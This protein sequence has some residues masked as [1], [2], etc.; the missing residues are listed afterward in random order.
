[1]SELKSLI[2]IVDDDAGIRSVLRLLMEREGYSV[3]EAATGV[4]AIA[5][6]EQHHPDVVLMDIRMPVMDGAAA[7]ARIQ[8]LPDG[9]R[10]P[11]LM[12][13]ALDDR[14]S[15]DRCFEAGATDYI[16]KPVNSAVMRQRVRRLLRTRQAEN[17]LRA[18]EARLASIIAI[19]ADAIVLTDAELNIRLFNP[20]AERIFG[21]RAA[22][23]M[24][25]P[26]DLLMPDWFVPV[27]ADRVMKMRLGE[28][29]G[30]QYGDYREGMGRH[31]DGHEFPIEISVGRIEE[32]P[33]AAYT[34][35][36]RDITRRKQAEA[37]IEQRVQ[38]LAALG[39]IGQVVTTQLELDG[40][41][42]A[43]IDQV[44]ARLQA[45]G[46]SVL[47]P[48]GDSEL[49]FAAVNGASADRLLGQRIPASAG[50]AGEVLHSG[51]AAR[52]Q[53]TNAHDRAYRD[54]EQISEYHARDIIAVPLKLGAEVIGVME[55]VH[56][57]PASFS[58]DDARLL[59]AAADWAAI[60]IG[61]ARQHQALQRRLQESE[62]MAA[63]GRALNQTLD[64]D[65][66]LKLIVNSAQRIIPSADRAA[67]I[68]VDD[69][70]NIASA[71]T[72]DGRIDQRL[73]DAAFSLNDEPY[74]TLMIDRQVVHLPDLAQQADVRPV[75]LPDQT[76]AMLAAPLQSGSA[77]FGVIS[78]YSLR[79]RAFAAEDERLL[80]MLGDEAAIA[81]HNARLYTSEHTQR[82]LAE[83]LRD[84][85]ATLTGTLDL[86]EVLDR[87]LDNAGRV[88][89]HDSA[90]ILLAEAGVARAARSRGYTD[91]S[92]NE[93][94]LARRYSIP[95]TPH[96][97]QMAEELHPLLIGNTARFEGWGELPQAAEVK[98]FVGAQIRFKRKLLGFL[99]LE[100][101]APDFF[102][103]EFADQLQVFANQAAVA[104][105]NAR[106]YQL[107][108]AQ[109]QQWQQSQSTVA[110]AEKM[111]ALG[112]LAALLAQ[113]I[114]R[115][116]QTIHQH[117]DAAIEG[118]G[119][120]QQPVTQGLEAARREVE[121]L[122]QTTRNV[123]DFA[124]PGAEALR[125]AP[126]D[127][128]LHHA[129]AL[130]AK[131][132]KHRQMQLTTDLQPTPLIPMAPDQM[133]QAIINILLNAIEAAGER[134]QIHL[135]T[136]VEGEQVTMMIINDGPAIKPNVLLHVGEP[137]FT[138]KTGHSG[139]GLAVSH[140]VVQ[141][142]GGTLVV[143]NLTND[144]GVVATIRLPC[145]KS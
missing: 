44:M 4:E 77:N 52:Q 117:L 19:S 36:L 49:M 43:V 65:T 27:H 14:D 109:F 35:T 134:G 87:I 22:E 34:I 127:D 139:L 8:Q 57:Q 18:S 26:S 105:E 123:L 66:I 115:P 32:N 73:A 99:C 86:D 71:V 111:S 125:P 33:Q 81:I 70:H 67:I 80:I 29:Y 93:R 42:Q 74:R 59:E 38:E 88:M 142:H 91:P 3:T 56:S 85:A 47:L 136:R 145:A 138:T 126:I 113:E 1:M 69:E 21:Y 45:E 53:S 39:Q 78:V 114:N 106:L 2:L 15:I 102:Q 112:R 31:Q 98:S 17:A 64:L 82:Q 96:L 143:E 63:I 84:T 100:S 72:E 37:E 46:V 62:V 90:T 101:H 54:I 61:N 110:Q 132:L 24:G 121:R 11:V 92:L 119:D 129:S 13:T 137:F 116:L 7:C 51:R 23:V 60:A 6:F 120:G 97:R 140:Q 20:G 94:V 41:L 5:A 55:A 83:A 40:A 79:Q 30:D 103:P 68:L 124:Q 9:D 25:Q 133:M 48:A 107:E 58:A 108:Q 131:P 76:R 95:D 12:I 16:T 130:V 75:G 104:I 122:D 10:T 89:P 50:L 28:T 135:V 118:V 144:R 141:R 128:V